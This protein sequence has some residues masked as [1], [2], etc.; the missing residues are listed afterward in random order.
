MYDVSQSGEAIATCMFR[1]LLM[2]VLDTPTNVYVSLNPAPALCSDV[3]SFPRAVH[4]TS[5]ST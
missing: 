4:F 3:E 5:H 2:H 1:W